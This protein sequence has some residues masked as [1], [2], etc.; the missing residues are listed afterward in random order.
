MGRREPYR[1]LKPTNQPPPAARPIIPQCMYTHRDSSDG[2]DGRFSFVNLVT[3]FIFVGRSTKCFVKFA[4]RRSETTQEGV[5][6]VL[7][8]PRDGLVL[9]SSAVRGGV[10]EIDQT[11]V[12]FVT[13]NQPAPFLLLSVCVTNHRLYLCFTIIC[14][15]FSEDASHR[16]RRRA[17]FVLSSFSHVASSPLRPR[18]RR[19]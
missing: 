9:I 2:C 14:A 16:S 19:R 1:H 15:P 10:V 4:L 3:G 13:C 12:K 18:R 11:K 5:I 6:V 17:T 8:R 7:E